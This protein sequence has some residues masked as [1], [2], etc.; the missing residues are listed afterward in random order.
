[1]PSRLRT[2]CLLAAALVALPACESPS[3]PEEDPQEEV[4]ERVEGI[5]A[6][7]LAQFPPEI[8][9]ERLEE[10][11][12][13]FGPCSVCHGLDGRGTQLAPSLRDPEWIHITGQPEEIAEIVRS[14][15]AQPREFPVPMPVGGG[16]A[17]S[18]EELASLA[19]YV[20]ALGRSGS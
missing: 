19:W 15:V 13:Q 10:G 8:T 4:T 17:F 2:N 5:S 16:G 1:M 14:G 9:M 12:R 7:V 20:Y 18:E 3:P 6:A 11:R